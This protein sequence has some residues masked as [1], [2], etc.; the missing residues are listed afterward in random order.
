[1]KII[2]AGFLRLKQLQETGKDYEKK[3]F[4]HNPFLKC[5]KIFQR[6]AMKYK[7]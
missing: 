4:F 5:E 3:S 6:V 2:P 1:M 7:N